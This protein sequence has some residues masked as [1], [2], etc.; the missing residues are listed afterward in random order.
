LPKEQKL[1]LLDIVRMSK[2]SNVLSVTYFVHKPNNPPYSL[3]FAFNSTNN[4]DID[5][6]EDPIPGFEVL[7]LVKITD[8]HSIFLTPKVFKWVNY[9]NKNRFAK[10]WERNMSNTKDIILAISFV[11]S[12][13]LTILQIY[14][15]LTTSLGK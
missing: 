10:W 8:Q 1:L 11:L 2:K 15:A 6:P 7:G 14:Q 12:L 5:L 13:A 9:E 4:I 3:S